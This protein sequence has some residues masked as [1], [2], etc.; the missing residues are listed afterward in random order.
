MGKIRKW[1]IFIENERNIE[2]PGVLV[3]QNEADI[4]S[5]NH[6]EKDI[7]VFKY[8]PFI[9]FQDFELDS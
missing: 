7:Q 1:G 5:Y 4:C 9:Y 6:H 2:S 8:I 3:Q